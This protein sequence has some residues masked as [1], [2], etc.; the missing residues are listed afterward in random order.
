MIEIP[1]GKVRSCYLALGPITKGRKAGQ[2][3]VF[4]AVSPL[5]PLAY[6][7]TGIWAGPESPPLARAAPSCRD[8]SK[9]LPL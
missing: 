2:N 1:A 5:R 7:H 9:H 4:D 8:V 6:L 3:L